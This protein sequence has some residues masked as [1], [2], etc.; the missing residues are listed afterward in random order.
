MKSLLPALAEPAVKAGVAVERGLDSRA[1]KEW[2]TILLVED[3]AS[4][5][6]PVSRMLRRYGYVVIEA[7]DGQTAADIFRSRSEEI[8]L[9]FLDL[10]LPGISGSEVLRQLRE[11]R[12]NV[13]VILTTAHS[14]EKA[15]ADLGGPPPWGFIRKPYRFRRPREAAAASAA[16]TGSRRLETADA[17]ERWPQVRAGLG[18]PTVARL[19]QR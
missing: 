4:L 6:L 8:E 1:A 14:E 18:F 15:L 11:L 5:R 3:E 17:R 12:P 10:T 16:R 19:T 9:V 2:G 7:G 13:K